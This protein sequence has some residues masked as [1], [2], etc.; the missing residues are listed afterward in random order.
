MSVNCEFWQDGDKCEI[1]RF[2]GETGMTV[3]GYQCPYARPGDPDPEQ[4]GL[5]LLGSGHWQDRERDAADLEGA[6]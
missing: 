4:C 2:I 1:K 3:L 5:R 6:T